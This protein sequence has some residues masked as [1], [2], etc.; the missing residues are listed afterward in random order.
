MSIK[1]DQWKL[2]SRILYIPLFLAFRKG[3]AISPKLVPCGNQNSPG[4]KNQGFCAKLLHQQK[5]K[6]FKAQGHPNECLNLEACFSSCSLQFHYCQV[7][8]FCLAVN[9]INKCSLTLSEIAFAQCL[10]ESLC[11]DY[12]HNNVQLP[13]NS[14]Y[15]MHLEEWLLKCGSVYNTH[16]WGMEHV[17]G[18]VSCI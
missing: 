11:I 9:T 5:H 10:L 7:L 8:R 4:A 13:P 1:A 14:H 17:N 2:T 18:I 3:D 12:A 6:H 15:L 16:V